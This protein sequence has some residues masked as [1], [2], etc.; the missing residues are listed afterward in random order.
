MKKILLI[1]LAAVMAFP[2]TTALSAEEQ[3]AAQPSP[4]VMFARAMGI[5]DSDADPAGTLTRIE[6]AEI[7]YNIIS[8]G[9]EHDNISES[10]FS[11]VTADEAGFAD[12][13]AQCGIM[14]GVSE[15][16]FDTQGQVTYIQLLKTLV[17]FLGYEQRALV[18]GGYPY[19]YLITAKDLGIVDE[20]TP[21]VDSVITVS[22]AATAFK[23]ATNVSVMKR[24]SFGS[25]EEYDVINGTTYLN[26]YLDVKRVRGIVTANYLVDFEGE[27]LRYDQVKIDGVKYYMESACADIKNYLGYKLDVYATGLKDDVQSIM[28]Y[29]T[30][31]NN[32]AVVVDGEDIEGISGTNVMYKEAE[33]TKKFAINTGTKVV[34]NAS[35][36]GNYDENTINPFKNSYKD[37]SVT[38]IDNNGDDICDLISVDAYD[39]YVVSDIVGNVI[40]NEYR[41]LE[42][43][44]LGEDYKEGDIEIVNI[45]NEPLPFSEISE[46]DIIS[47]SR[48][49]FGAVR[50][51]AVTIDSYTGTVNSFNDEDNLI[52]IDETEFKM[53]RS[54]QLNPQFADLNPGDKVMVY[55]NKD[56]KV[57]DIEAKAY[58]KYK[59]GYI[60]DASMGSLDT[61]VEVKLFTSGDTFEILPLAEKVTIR[62]M[63]KRVTAKDAI[64][65]AGTAEGSGKIQRQPIL[66]K[67]NVNGE[68]NWIDYSM[69]TTPVDG[70]FMYEGFDG[71]TSRANAPYRRSVRS[72]GAKLLISDATVIFSVPDEEHRDKDDDY[73]VESA[74]IFS[75]NDTS[76]LFEA[77]GDD[78]ETPCAKILVLK[79]LAKDDIDMYTDVFAV[80][81]IKDEIDEDGSAIKKVYGIL[82]GTQTSYVADPE[83]INVKNGGLPEKGDI[84]RLGISKK[85]KINYA[86]MVFDAEAREIAGG[87]NPSNASYNSSVRYSYGDVIYSDGSYMKVKIA[88]S[89]GDII[90]SYPI[91]SFKMVELDKTNGKKGVLKSAS[92]ERLFGSDNYPG[93]ASK[94]FIHTRNGDVRTLAIYND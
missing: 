29:E 87:A 48:D 55:F 10:R 31:N 22:K 62:S 17:S 49:A 33:K 12:F 79:G 11:D 5:I 50:R 86:E 64:E 65:L 1:L 47:V 20:M 90:E 57:S 3:Q 42:V 44:D 7:Y 9:V 41:P 59:I 14:N 81:E 13:V 82:Y 46:G 83:I 69:G 61:A 36:C 23:L 92:K 78:K 72:F 51:I 26:M 53:S 6:L 19:G 16:E 77:Y 54:L 24:I 71:K 67:T 85:G 91:N 76:K 66:Y 60:V 30:V 68:I 73:V 58:E 89:G 32:T 4:D 45:L 21:S 63:D 34:Y 84:L 52:G 35:L 2:L 15:T 8:N 74:N 56:G 39:T 93:Y 80:D 27:T 75:E 43:V 38:L 88:G 28:Y 25:A 40:F 37:G 70:L 94:V 18:N